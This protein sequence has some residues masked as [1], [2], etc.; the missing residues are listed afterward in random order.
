[1]QAQAKDDEKD[2][3]MRTSNRGKRDYVDDLDDFLEQDYGGNSSGDEGSE[4]SPNQSKK[5]KPKFAPLSE[6]EESDSKC[7]RVCAQNQ[8]DLVTLPCK[9]YIC[10]KCMAVHLRAALPHD[11]EGFITESLVQAWEDEAG[12]SVGG[13]LD[14]LSD[15]MQQLTSRLFGIQRNPAPKAEKVEGAPGGDEYGDG[16][17]P[18]PI[19]CQMCCWTSSWEKAFEL[20]LASSRVKSIVARVQEA[21]ER[22]ASAKIVMFSKF[23]S[24]LDIIQTYLYQRGLSTLRYDGTMNTTERADTVQAFSESSEAR[25]LLVSITAGGVGLNLTAA[26]EAWILVRKITREMN[27]SSLS[28]FFRFFVFS[29]LGRT[30]ISTQQSNCKPSTAYI[31]LGSRAR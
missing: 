18:V 29:S 16:V 30:I 23:R 9:H 6:T 22:D 1:M 8:D 17:L 15:R 27:T 19:R 3:F 20:P 24:F 10:R 25:I 13:M 2:E 5:Q 11:T 26:T 4:E 21:L 28:H 31:G 12:E 7:C 14:K